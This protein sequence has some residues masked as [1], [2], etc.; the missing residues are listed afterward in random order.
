MGACGSAGNL[1]C[2]SSDRATRKRRASTFATFRPDENRFRPGRAGRFLLAPCRAADLRQRPVLW[3][4]RDMG[5]ARA[6][7][8]CKPGLRFSQFPSSQKVPRLSYYAS[9]RTSIAWSSWQ[10][11]QIIPPAGSST[12]GMAAQLAQQ[13][14]GITI[15]SPMDKLRLSRVFVKSTPVFSHGFSSADL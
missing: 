6:T 4:G 1:A 14:G 9:W 8:R 12:P 7:Y 10:A 15:R 2:M 5:N 11:D 13:R 3:L